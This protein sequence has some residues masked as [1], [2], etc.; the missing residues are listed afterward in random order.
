[1]TYTVGPGILKR[2]E[3]YGTE[4]ATD[5]AYLPRPDAWTYS[6]AFGMDGRRYVYLRAARQVLSFD[7]TAWIDE[8]ELFHPA[9]MLWPAVER[10]AGILGAPLANVR[11]NWP[12]VSAALDELGIGDRATRIAALGTIGVE[13]GAFAPIH[14]YGSDAYFE[15][16]YGP[17]TS[18]GQQL[19]NVNPG[20][21]ARYHG[22]GL[23][24]IT[25]RSNYRRYG[26]RLGVDL[27]G[28]PDLALDPAT[29]AR[30]L[31]TYFLDHGIPARAAAGDWAGV[32][33]A[34]NGGLAGWD[35]FATIVEALKTL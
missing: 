21:G 10:V 35:R 13:V 17:G 30:V 19:G 29:S 8:D 20:D 32:R 2:M 28:N 34:V 16:N 15:A 31:A 5:E 33:R 4:P 12:L 25:G 24:Q 18:A 9:P 23:I 22:R 1:M 11:A 14:E 27:E 3:Q 26:Q 6:E 7:P